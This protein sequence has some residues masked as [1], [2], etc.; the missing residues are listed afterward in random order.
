MEIGTIA[1]AFA[2]GL[3]FYGFLFETLYLLSKKELCRS[4]GRLAGGAW[5]L[6]LFL[7]LSVVTYGTHSLPITY[8]LPN[9]VGDLPAA[10]V[11]V[12]LAL[13]GLITL[14]SGVNKLRN[15]FHEIH[16]AKLKESIKNYRYVIGHYGCAPDGIR[17]PRDPKRVY[18]QD[19][20]GEDHQDAGP[21]T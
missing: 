6:L 14:G 11:L 17:S 15:Y 13:A 19:L 4:I 21:L 12:S 16:A 8:Q 3:V 20:Q 10:V 7:Y 5:R 9:G 1:Q 2:L 18:P